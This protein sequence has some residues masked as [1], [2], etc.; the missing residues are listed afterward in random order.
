MTT[1]N[2][3]PESQSQAA[4]VGRK[5]TWLEIEQQPVVWPTTIERVREGAARLHLQSTLQD[6]RVVITGAGTSAYAAA[7]VA[8]AWP[9][10]IAVPSTDL[11]LAAERYVRD[12]NVVVSLARSGDSPESM[13]VVE[14][15]HR[16]RPDV[17]HLAITCN[18]RG[19][20]ATS[21][22][23][24]PIVLDPRTND[25]SLVMTSSFSNL[26]LAGLCLA[27]ESLMGPLITRAAAEAQE[28]FVLIDEQ[29]KE[30]AHRVEDRLV[31]LASAPLFGWA[32]EGA[33]KVLEMAAGR[34]PVIAESYLGLR[35][36]PM[37]FVRTNTMVI[38][39]LANDPLSRRYE[40]DLVRELRA[41]KLGY[42]VG[43]CSDRSESEDF[44]ELFDAAIPA[45]LP[46][47]PDAVRTPFEILALQLFAYHLS[48]R[49]GLNPDSPSPAGVINRVVQGIHIYQ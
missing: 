14:R 12:A 7:A 37:S 24:N 39:V 27:N 43:I 18:S 8:P 40:V 49:A 41:K 4:A 33:L 16:L 10:S 3:E 29:M 45:L 48:L 36:G 35:H 44:T 38:C 21:P 32:Q 47:A 30:L 34:F 31:L 9:R 20:L 13:A 26:V 5:H 42:L 23:V 19:A 15:I 46:R 6:A 17:W 2:G 28:R 25:Q 11:L 22:L 1:R